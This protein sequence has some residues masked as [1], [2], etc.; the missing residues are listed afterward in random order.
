MGNLI[1]PPFIQ[2]IN[3]QRARSTHGE[4]QN[5]KLVQSAPFPL[6]SLATKHHVF[7]RF[8]Q[9]LVL[10][11]SQSNIRTHRHKISSRYSNL[12][13]MMQPMPAI[14]CTVEPILVDV[15]QVVEGDSR[16]KRLHRKSN[17]VRIDKNN[18]SQGI[19]FGSA[20]L[21]SSVSVLVM[22][23]SILCLFQFDGSG[24]ESTTPL[25]VN[26]T[27]KLPSSRPKISF[28]PKHAGLS[29]LNEDGFVE[30]T[31]TTKEGSCRV[32][33][34]PRDKKFLKV[35]SNGPKLNINDLILDDSQ[36]PTK[37]ALPKSMKSYPCDSVT[38]SKMR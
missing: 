20:S 19:S 31:F 13:K 2:K 9:P 29:P 25:M 18:S 37:M 12:P 16:S 17:R 34:L 32:A 24:L 6:G 22:I 10:I 7:L 4:Y 28:A 5:S 38:A 1:G 23:F 8:S 15:V 14:T 33:H 27:I 11:L 36:V 30:V 35:D 26:Q 21:S 3:I